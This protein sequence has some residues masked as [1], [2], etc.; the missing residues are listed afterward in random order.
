MILEIEDS[1]KDVLTVLD[2]R[3]KDWF[4]LLEIGRR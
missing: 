4:F 1:F 2:F 3:G